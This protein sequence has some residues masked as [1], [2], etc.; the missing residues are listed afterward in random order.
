M[1]DAAKATAAA[2]DAA[3]AAA[4]A[5]VEDTAAEPSELIELD[6]DDEN[7]SDDDAYAAFK[8]IND[9]KATGVEDKRDLLLD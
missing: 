6:L 8:D 7:D 4:A 5:A 3:K 9:I 1:E 2:E